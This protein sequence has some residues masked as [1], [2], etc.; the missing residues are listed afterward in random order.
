MLF[1][2]NGVKTSQDMG[3]HRWDIVLE[4]LQQR[5]EK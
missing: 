2:G 5:L 4:E 1:I 3:C